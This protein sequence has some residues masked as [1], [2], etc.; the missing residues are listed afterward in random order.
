MPTLSIED[1]ASFL[2]YGEPLL[3]RGIELYRKLFPQAPMRIAVENLR[4]EGKF[5]F[6]DTLLLIDSPDVSDPI[7]ASAF[8]LDW[9]SDAFGNYHD[10]EGWVV[11][12]YING[13]QIVD[14]LVPEL[15]IDEFEEIMSGEEGKVLDS[16][17]ERTEP[18]AALEYVNRLRAKRGLES[19]EPVICL[20]HLLQHVER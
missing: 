3:W 9:W 16:G 12:V 10:M 11:D 20:D 14:I 17:E 6:G 4:D 18:D 19:V 2:R 15:T 8:L 13:E 5:T 1:P 7:L